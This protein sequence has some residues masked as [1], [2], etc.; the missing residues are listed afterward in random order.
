MYISKIYI[1]FLFFATSSYHLTLWLF[2]SW[3]FPHLFH[4][5]SPSFLLATFSV[6]V[7]NL[8]IILPLPYPVDTHFNYVINLGFILQ[9]LSV[10]Y[11]GF[12]IVGGRERAV[13]T[14]WNLTKIS[15]KSSLLINHM[16]KQCFHVNHC[17]THFLH[18]HLLLQIYCNISIMLT[19]D[20]IRSSKL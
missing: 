18:V 19:F 11:Q 15:L 14:F 5:P 2:L 6:C 13:S 1:L 16:C 12:L 4:S 10:L 20:Q 9:H 8:C 17:G 3:N 7:S